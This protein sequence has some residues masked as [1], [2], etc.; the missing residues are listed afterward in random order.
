MAVPD[1]DSAVAVLVPVALACGL[2]VAVTVPLELLLG[3]KNDVVEEK[4]GV[5]DGVGATA[6]HFNSRDIK[7]SAVQYQ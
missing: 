7:S 4:V 6:G 1:D 2:A 5:E 3:A